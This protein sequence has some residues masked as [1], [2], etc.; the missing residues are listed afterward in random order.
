[1]GSASCIIAASISHSDMTRPAPWCVVLGKGVA[2]DPDDAAAA[3]DGAAAWPVR[4]GADAGGCAGRGD[5]AAAAAGG[6]RRPV[7]RRGAGSL[8]TQNRG[9]PGREVDA[10]DLSVGP[11]P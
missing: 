3:G 10:A 5:G 7:V 2:N 4:R 8:G 6:E 9:A 1:M 11:D